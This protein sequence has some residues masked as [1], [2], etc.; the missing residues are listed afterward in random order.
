MPAPAP[1][2]TADDAVDTNDA[3]AFLGVSPRTLEDWRCRSGGG[4]VFHKIGR[5]LVRYRV[6]AL[7]SF[8]ADAARTNTSGG[9]PA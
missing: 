6:S 7:E 9:L 3:A 8:M 2:A 4:P 5:R 1:P